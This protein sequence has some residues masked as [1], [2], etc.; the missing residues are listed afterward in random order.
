MSTYYSRA[1]AMPTTTRD[2]LANAIQ[3]I[4]NELEAGNAREALLQAVDV[5][6][7]VRSQ[8]NPYR[9]AV[10]P[11]RKRTPEYRGTVNTD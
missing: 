1:I 4:I 10:A 6:D 7:D 5:L 11:A 2:G 9:I 8:A 3:Q